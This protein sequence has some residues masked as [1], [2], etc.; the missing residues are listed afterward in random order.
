LSAVQGRDALIVWDARFA[1]KPAAV[2]AE[3]IA[4]EME[5]PSWAAVSPTGNTWHGRKNRRRNV[6]KTPPVID[7]SECSD[8][9][10]CVE[11][12]PAV[13]VRNKETGLMEV[14]DLEEYPQQE[15]EEVM[16][17]CPQDCIRL[18]EET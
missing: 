2:S 18:S 12:C 11:L 16:S 6:M 5:S 8:C 15:I 7:I 17:Y 3:R 13:F 9:G 14:R 4:T 1:V 10:T